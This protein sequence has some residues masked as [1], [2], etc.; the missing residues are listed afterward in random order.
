MEIDELEVGN[1][2]LGDRCLLLQ[3]AIEVHCRTFYSH[4]TQ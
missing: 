1:S 3:N 4:L 2:V